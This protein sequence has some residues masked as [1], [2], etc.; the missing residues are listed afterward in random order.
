MRGEKALR[1][2][3]SMRSPDFHLLST[4][5]RV[6][7]INGGLVIGLSDCRLQVE[8]EFGVPQGID[9]A[10]QSERSGKDGHVSQPAVLRTTV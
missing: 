2:R 7:K 1:L 5:T 4:Q 6:S 3:R 9:L 10:G 8:Y